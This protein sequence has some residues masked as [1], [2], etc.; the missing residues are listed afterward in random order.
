MDR[1]LLKEK[2]KEQLKNNLFV[3]I[4]GFLITLITSLLPLSFIFEKPRIIL[5]VL[6]ILLLPIYVGYAR[7][8]YEIS[9]NENG[10]ISLLFPIVNNQ[11]YGR[12]LIG[13]IIYLISLIAWTSLFIIPGIYKLF[14]YAMTSLVLQDPEFSHLN[15]ILAISKSREIMNGHKLEYF[16]L[17][18]SFIGWYLLSILT[19]GLALVYVIPYIK[20]TKT[21]FYIE[22]KK[23]NN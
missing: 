21:E 5:I 14:S 18:V 19:L 23:E 8:S 15:G 17:L 2:A 1:Q 3:L 20:Q 13:M 7:L 6:F 22:L 16:D 11:G 4:I 10:K 9:K 12:E